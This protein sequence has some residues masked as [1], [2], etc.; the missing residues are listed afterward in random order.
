MGILNKK[1]ILTLLIVFIIRILLS[2]LPAFE[3]D[4][5]AFRSWSQRLYEIGPANFYSQEVFTNNPIGF[6]YFLWINGVIKNTLFESGLS[7]IYF[8]ILLKLT[9]NI[10]DILTGLI[11]Y[12]ILKKKLSEK[13]GYIGFLLYTLNPAV[14]FNSSV[15]GQYDGLAALFL[16]LALYFIF[17]KNSYY[18]S[19][20]FTAIALTL[21][22]QTI[23][24]IPFY[25]ILLI[26][27]IKFFKLLKIAVTGILTLLLIYFPFFPENPLYGLIYVNRGSSQLFNCT[28]CFALNFWGIFGNWKDDSTTVLNISYLL[29]GIV[30][31][32]L[33]LIPILFIR[34]LKLRL[35]EPIAYLTLAL[36]L[37][38]SFMLLTRMHERYLFPM[39]PFLLIGALFVRNK[40]FLAFYFLFSI[41]Y[42]VNLYLPYS[43][44]NNLLKLT[45]FPTFNL[46]SYFETFSLISL[47]I[48]IGFYLTYFLYI[49]KDGKK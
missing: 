2:F 19:A 42:F 29:W 23:A 3:Y 15:W 31:F 5:S 9:S 4:Q 26:T 18:L 35:Q 43:Y 28:T 20:I 21:K 10:A 17:Q 25:G 13:L 45:L 6:L 7:N 38:T 39:L 44:Y 40:I 24:F 32:T 46:T 14:W 8:D 12:V 22:P 49:N 37:T 27:N 48:F 30:L 16:V 41:I 47:I 33:A 1:I 34:P 36:S 11:I